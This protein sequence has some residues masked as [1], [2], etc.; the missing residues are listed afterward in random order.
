M[1]ITAT[2]RAAIAPADHSSS[3]DL[4]YDNDRSSDDFAGMFAGALH[5]TSHKPEPKKP[6]EGTSELDKQEEQPKDDEVKK[7]KHRGHGHRVGGAKNAAVADDAEDTDALSA[8]TSADEI[9]QSTAA[10]DPELQAKLARVAA[11]M[12]DEAGTDVKVA[13][14]YR[15]QGRQN[16]LFAQGRETPGDI[17]T[18]TRNSKH[19]QGRAVDLMLDGGPQGFDAYKTLQRI[20]QEEGLRTLGAKDPGH[21]ELPGNVTSAQARVLPGAANDANTSLPVEPAD[22]TGPGQVSIARIAQVAQVAEVSAVAKPAEVAHVATVA[23]V[24]KV[25]APGMNA[26]GNIKSPQPKHVAGPT[27]ADAA[28]AENAA[29]RFSGDASADSNAEERGSKSGGRGG[30]GAL[31]AAVAMRESASLF[32]G[33]I[34]DAASTGG[35]SPADRAARIISMYED[36]PARPLSQ[37]TMSVDSGNGTMD[38]IQVA[39]RG[40]SLNATIDAADAHGAQTMNSRADELVRALS[41]D[42]LSVESLHV[43]AAAATT[44]VG[45]AQQSSNS[46]DSSSHSRSDRSNPWQQQD[47]QRSND[48]RR[49]QQRNRRGGQDQ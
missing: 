4:R 13:E 9:V 32:H 2:S 23:N 1:T 27:V 30:Y 18:W 40:S 5:A 45:T 41:K 47:R 26:D 15:S 21:L 34:Q 10:L 35:L 11:R 12:R 31:A 49:Q 14:T 7:A 24:A 42:G 29:Q 8:P 37:I 36:A 33:A 16:A 48:D 38:R 44:T 20:A 19:T 25:Q 43:R 39:L 17:V 22:A 3:R 6:N 46:S 28:K